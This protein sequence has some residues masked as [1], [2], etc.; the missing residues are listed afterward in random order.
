MRA[1]LR[2]PEFLNLLARPLFDPT[3]ASTRRRA[4]SLALVAL[5]VASAMYELGRGTN[6]SESFQLSSSSVYSFEG[7]P[8]FLDVSKNYGFEVGR[9]VKEIWQTSV[10]DAQSSWNFMA[11]ETKGNIPTRAGVEPRSIE[12]MTFHNVGTV[13]QDG[14]SFANKMPEYPLVVTVWGPAAQH[15]TLVQNFEQ[16]SLCREKLLAHVGGIDRVSMG[17]DYL[18]MYARIK[19]RMS[20]ST[21][22]KNFSSILSGIIIHTFERL[23]T[24]PFST[25]LFQHRPLYVQYFF[26]TSD[27]GRDS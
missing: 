11:P 23:L 9:A 15:A 16:T 6:E 17:K 26:R 22:G 12:Q 1:K 14:I 2:D 21:A 3:S 5:V 7:E 27:R 20:G 8:G 4:L 19:T 10:P 13:E 25:F 24:R 18:S